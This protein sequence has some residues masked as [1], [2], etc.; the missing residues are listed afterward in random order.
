M[1]FSITT[2]FILIATIGVPQQSSKIEE[3]TETDFCLAFKEVLAEAT[4]D[5][6]GIIAREKNNGSWDLQEV[7]PGAM[8]L[9]DYQNKAGDLAF[10]M[11]A[12]N[13]LAK[14]KEDF[15]KLTKWIKVC[16]GEKSGLYVYSEDYTP[17]KTIPYA[18]TV[19]E[20]TTQEAILMLRVMDNSESETELPGISHSYYCVIEFM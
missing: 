6:R 12:N 3:A 18:L 17:G 4:D 1:K 13:E 11:D 7:M 10:L 8:R 14:I 15:D 20:K 19:K 2:I 16:L 9:Y 5:Y